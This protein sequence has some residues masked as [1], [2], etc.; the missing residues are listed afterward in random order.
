M[1]RVA[2]AL[3]SISLATAQV[4]IP[5][6]ITVANGAS[7]VQTGTAAPGSMLRIDLFPLPDESAT[8][9]VTIGV[10]ILPNGARFAME[11]G[12][13][14]Q[15]AQFLFPNQVTAVLP[16]SLP[17]GPAQL[18]LYYNGVS[19][20]KQILIVESSLGLFAPG[21][22]YPVQQMGS[23]GELLTNQLTH[24]AK[25]GDTVTLWATGLG[26]ATQATVLL[27]GRATTSAAAGPVKGMPGVDQIQFVVPD[28][29]TIPNDCYVALAVETPDLT[30]NTITISKTSDGSV[31]QSTLGLSAEDLAML[32]AG[33]TVGLAQLTLS[34]QVGA[35]VLS[36]RTGDFLLG[37]PTVGLPVPSSR[38][39][40]RAE[41]ADF[42]PQMVNA[43]LVAQ[44]SGT[45]VADEAFFGCTAASAG[46]LAISGVFA[47]PSPYDFGKAVTLQGAGGTLSLTA[48]LG[49]FYEGQQTS[50]TVPDPGALA[51]PL[52]TAGDWTFSGQGG[53][54]G[55]GVVATSPF[56]V[57]LALP[58]EIMATNFTA[59]QT[60][61]RQQ[62]LT[63][64]WN[65]SGFGAGDVLTVTL[66]GYAG[67]LYFSLSGFAP[68]SQWFYVAPGQAAVWCNMPASSGQVVIPAAMVGRLTPGKPGGPPNATVSL[69]VN[70]RPGH[71]QTFSLPLS[72]GTSLPVVLQF[73]SSETWPVMVQ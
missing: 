29:A 41:L 22:Q 40:A 52:F 32:D 61:N 62:D 19:V 39:F 70:Q 38:G 10:T 6:Q 34:A 56:S 66:G 42:R 59:L 13:L 47:F 54:G 28:D 23:D 73:S 5:P 20:S 68:I 26:T 37:V 43:S 27:G 12:I 63:V 57:P 71:R 33:G 25:P 45:V 58:T 4:Q 3:F 8:N 7:L 72:D 51:M 30:S 35:P 48:P 24:P 53:T 1:H 9:S 14:P 15:T 67:P 18:T 36:V 60:I 69:S 31:C 46:G 65:P 21:A 49:P 50:P 17:L 44:I 2:I 55:Q 16:S 64:M 11:C